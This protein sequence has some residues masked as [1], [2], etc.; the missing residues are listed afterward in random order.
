VDGLDLKRDGAQ[1][2][3]AVLDGAWIERLRKVADAAVGSRPG[4]RLTA[5]D[6]L[7]DL[8]EPDGPVGLIAAAALG[9]RSHAVRAVMFDKSAA[10]NW[11]VA[12]HQ[13]RTI[14]VR[15]RFDVRGF[16][17]WSRKDGLLH[18]APPVEVLESMVTLRVHLDDVGP[19]NAPLDVALGS[20]RRGLVPAAEATAVAEG[21]DLCACLAEAGDVWA[22]RTLILHASARAVRPTRR[23][24][25]QIDF[26]AM[27]LPDGLAWQ[28]LAA[29]DAA[30]PGG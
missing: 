2:Y 20:H 28:G 13:D 30:K 8:L 9:P 26:G 12:W 25:L 4:A 10:S 19:D 3:R 14:A 7:L 22:Y 1:L 18:V 15:E 24:V 29:D 16:G 27:D 5:Q 11:A 21:H 23:R 6:G 17:P